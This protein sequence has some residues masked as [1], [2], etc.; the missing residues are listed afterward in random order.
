MLQTG[1]NLIRMESELEKEIELLLEELAEKEYPEDLIRLL[2]TK[3]H[4][5]YDIQREIHE[6]LKLIREDKNV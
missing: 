5:L 2:K 4:D 3:Q 6:L 1:I